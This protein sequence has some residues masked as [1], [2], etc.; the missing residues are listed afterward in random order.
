MANKTRISLMRFQTPENQDGPNGGTP[1]NIGSCSTFTGTGPRLIKSQS[2][3][4]LVESLAQK[5]SIPKL[6]HGKKTHLKLETVI[7]NWKP[8]KANLQNQKPPR[9]P[10]SQIS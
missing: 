6:P 10:N 8:S 2:F 4:S 3:S 1:T 5:S 9:R 7:E